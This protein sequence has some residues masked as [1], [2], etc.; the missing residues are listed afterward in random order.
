MLVVVNFDVLAQASDIRIER[1]QV[2]FYV[3][4][5]FYIPEAALDN[6]QPVWNTQVSISTPVR[7]NFELRPCAGDIHICWFNFNA[8][9]QGN[10][11]KPTDEP[12]NY[13]GP[14]GD[15]T[16]DLQIE[17]TPPA[18]S[19]PARS[20]H[21]TEL[22]SKNTNPMT[23]PRLHWTTDNPSGMHRCQFQHLCVLILNCALALAMKNWTA[24]PIRLMSEHSANLA[25]F[26][27][28]FTPGSSDISSLR[29]SNK[30]Y[31][32][33]D[34]CYLLVTIASASFI[35]IIIIT[36]NEWRKLCFCLCWFIT[37]QNLQFLASMF[38]CRFVTCQNLILASMFV[39]HVCLFVT[40]QNLQFLASMFVCRFVTCQNLQFLASMFVCRFV[41]CQNL[42]FLASMFV[43]RGVCLSVC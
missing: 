19:C 14:G 15:R 21:A 2:V 17:A 16:H 43:C 37:C 28:D 32:T 25:H 31:M 23:C 24:Q 36:S 22:V 5:H 26:L 30:V 13:R 34:N 6:C 33:E 38:V 20:L 40:C 9:A 29:V 42:Q 10:A 3:Y 1:R 4:I 7:V 39:A 11:Y 35:N 12:I 27:N 41:T 18:A 8:L